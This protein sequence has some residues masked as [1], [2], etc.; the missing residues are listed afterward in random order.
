MTTQTSSPLLVLAVAGVDLERRPSPLGV[1][2][3]L[4]TRRPARVDE[5]A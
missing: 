4:V 5:I 3:D 1:S 2:E